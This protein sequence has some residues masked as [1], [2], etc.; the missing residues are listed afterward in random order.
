MRKRTD[1][2]HHRPLYQLL[3][4]DHYRIHLILFALVLASF[5]RFWHLDI[6][7]PGLYHDEA[8][9]GLDA[10]SLIQGKSFPQFYEGWEQYAQDAHTSHT[11]STTRFPVFFEGNYG[12]EPM[13]IYLMV[14]SIKLFGATPFAIRFVPALSGVIA[15]WTTYLAASALVQNMDEDVQKAKQPPLAPIFSAFV[16]AILYPAVHF[17]R[18]G[19]RAML[20]VPIETLTVYCFW[21]GINI[22]MG[23][24]PTSGNKLWFSLSGVFLGL[25]LYTYAAARLFPLLFVGFILVWFWRD[26]KAFQQLWRPIALMAS[27][28]I[29]V[30]V[31]L[32]VFFAR[33]PYFFVFRIAYVANKGKGTVEGKPWLTWL[34]NTGRVVKGLFWQGETHL[35]HNLPGRPYL[36]LIQA[37]VFV[38]G[39]GKILGHWR[40]LRNLFLLLWLAM[41]LLP[42]ILSGDAPHFGRMTGAAPVFAILIGLG[43]DWLQQRVKTRL[44]QAGD[45]LLDSPATIISYWL[46][47]SLFLVSAFST[48]RDYFQRYVHHPD[49]PVDFYLPDW[50]LGQYAATQPP[51]TTIYLTPTQEEMATIY[52]ALADPDRLRSYTGEAGLV[53]AGQPDRP[54]LYL[55]RPDDAVSLQ[56]LSSFFPVGILGEA[57]ENFFPF[58]VPTSAPRITA[59]H[60]LKYSWDGK[61]GLVGWSTMEQNNQ[62]F[63]TLFWQA[64]GKIERNFTAFVHLVNESDQ[65]ITQKDRPP[66]GYPTSDWREGEIVVDQYILDLPYELPPGPYKLETGWYYLPTLEGLGEA[67]ALTDQWFVKPGD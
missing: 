4:F 34:N 40:H 53:P 9:N 43:A 49:V 57:Q 25:G 30:A 55:V 38:V 24:Q 23:E 26:R 42:T 17:S 54:A 18:F 28:S 45:H 39:V 33:F 35:R 37:S 44:A 6:L 66:A 46:L 19:I 32:L 1:S 48:G 13:H 7:P 14:L 47:V 20:F 41:M 56:K 58:Q 10:L 62:L 63:V 15:V 2:G 27:I 12:R 64:K 31:P 36:D 22:S 52:F 67:A 11:P 51:E 50:K 29:L 16:L 59:D 5:F 65:L 8:Y 61:I 3:I 21:R 60:L